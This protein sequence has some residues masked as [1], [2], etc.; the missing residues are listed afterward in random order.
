MALYSFL[1]LFPRI[2]FEKP[3]LRR[4]KSRWKDNIFVFKKRVLKPCTGMIWLL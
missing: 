4:P 3:A 2:I 1:L